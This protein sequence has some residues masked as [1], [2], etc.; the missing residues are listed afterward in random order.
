[1]DDP[2][3]PNVPLEGPPEITNCDRE[4]VHAPGAIQQF[5]CLLAV[6]ADN[7]IVQASENC[8]SMLGIAAGDLLERDVADALPQ[9]AESVKALSDVED[10]KRADRT[11]IDIA[12][13]TWSLSAHACDGL[14]IVELEPEAD[15]SARGMTDLLGKLFI[16]MDG[17]SLE[18]VYN[19]VVQQI[20]DFTGFDRVMLYQF[21]ED[22]HGS[23]VAEAKRDDQ[24][25]F[26]GLHYPAG[27][28]PVP[29]RRLY[30]LNWI[31]TLADVNAEPISMLTRR[32]SD[33]PINMAFAALRAISPIHLEYLRN[34]GVGA[35]MS[36]SVM[37]GERLW[38]LI[39]CHHNSPKVI[40]PTLR[41]A[42]E[43]AGSLLSTYLSS[44]HQQQYLASQLEIT[45]SIGQQMTVMAGQDDIADGLER[46]A[47]S[48]SKALS[49]DGMVW[50][51]GED[52]FCWGEVP[53]D[54]AIDQII[55][56]LDGR[57]EDTIAF[58]D[59]LSKWLADA[60]E[61]AD[62]VAGLLA[63][64][65]GRREGGLLMFFRKPYAATVDWAGDPSKSV[66]E[67]NGRLTPRK[68]FAK[69]QQEVQGRSRPWNDRDRMT[70]Q[71]LLSALSAMVV[72]QS[73]RLHRANQELR[74][75][76][77]DLDAFAYAASHDLKE[78]LRGI[79]HYAYLLEQARD[80]AGEDYAR[81]LDGLK[82]IIKRMSDLLDGLL[83]FSRAGRQEL[84]IET[85]P[86][87]EVVSQ[88]KDI[89]FSEIE[90]DDVRVIVTES[91]NI[92]GDFACVREILS[93]LINNAIK[94]NESDVKQIEIGVIP[95][96]RTPLAGKFP[97]VKVVYVRDNGIGIE[98]ARH[99][100]IFEI[101]HR[102]HDRDAFGG[103][104]GAGL[105]I[106]RRMVERHGGSIIPESKPGEGTT[107][108]FSLG[109]PA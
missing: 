50:Q 10:G 1:M 2:Q 31:R 81:S 49:A 53:D 89:L 107:F 22:Y 29:A 98:P 87:E 16:N 26:L 43:M 103:G 64:R 11:T 54:S 9:S 79:H 82:R 30:E 5:G 91:A 51:S 44:R 105:T 33:R 95:A 104:S 108:Y 37:K 59:S 57:S 78:P 63:M 74:S 14:R 47:P 93:N 66:T 77:A 62:R 48:M 39:A 55:G 88:A 42:C 97:G 45:E 17:K 36:I 68:S 6:D 21:H 102:L 38:G 65:L 83:R 70:A 32:D 92:Q 71:S 86:L 12:D 69:F 23:V 34:M 90:P 13:R 52:R 3:L 18:Q 25:A 56:A 60:V 7:T 94:Y 99:E 8:E 41:D 20:R 96:E 72:E 80:L 28:I 101:F 46:A 61:Y 73:A 24:E 67:E 106:V 15:D 100:Q 84:D 35:S 19:S 27:D 4:P 75:L 85:F 40:S 58:T 76:N 109:A